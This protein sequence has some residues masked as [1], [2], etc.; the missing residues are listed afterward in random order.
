[1]LSPNLFAL[2]SAILILPKV[3]AISH[4]TEKIDALDII[5]DRTYRGLFS[6][7]FLTFGL[8]E[9]Q[10]ELNAYVGLFLIGLQMRKPS[11]PLFLGNLENQ[12]T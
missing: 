2:G 5:P 6:V 1:M 10:K 4:V 12:E 11:L 3:S 7:D 9:F 8:E